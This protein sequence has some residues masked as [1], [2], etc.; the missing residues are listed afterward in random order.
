MRFLN[1]RRV[2]L[3][4]YLTAV[5]LMLI[6][7]SWA[8]AHESAEHAGSGFRAGI[9]HPLTG[10]DHLL[11]LIAVAC[12]ST[13]VSRLKAKF[14][15]VCFLLAL[16]SGFLIGL[17]GIGLTF[18]EN[19][20]VLSLLLM[21]VLLISTC[22]LPAFASGVVIAMFGVMHGVPHGLEMPSSVSSAAYFLGLMLASTITLGVGY[23]AAARF[24]RQQ[25]WQRSLAFALCAVALIT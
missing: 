20:I 14:F 17:S 6:F 15:S 9:L 8:L 16:A 13:R 24:T 11:M 12:F 18:V 22:Q 2:G 4:L 21:A 10:V 1:D 5:G 23:V 3:L 19:G 25:R 7:P